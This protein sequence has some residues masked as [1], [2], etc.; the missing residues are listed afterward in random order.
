MLKQFVDG[1]RV[2]YRSPILRDMLDI[3][4][5]I[6]LSTKIFRR[7]AE[8]ACMENGNDVPLDSVTR[9]RIVDHICYAPPFRQLLPFGAST[10]ISN[11][12]GAQQ[13]GCR[14]GLRHQRS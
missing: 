12:E 7:G 11:T 5:D 9:R 14:L 1:W 3:C 10:E 8:I 4:G 6:C 2:D 13:A